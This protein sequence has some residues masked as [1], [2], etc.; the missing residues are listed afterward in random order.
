MTN[1]YLIELVVESTKRFLLKIKYI[2]NDDI[3]NAGDDDDDVL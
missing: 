2:I 1:I 3:D